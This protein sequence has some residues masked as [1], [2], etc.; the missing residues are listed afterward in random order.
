M[1]AIIYSS[2]CNGDYYKGTDLRQGIRGYSDSL[3][4]AIKFSE[5]TL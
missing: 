2:I 4:V 1:N 5:Y 3:S